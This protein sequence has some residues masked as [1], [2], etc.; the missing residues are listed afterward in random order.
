MAQRPRGGVLPV[1]ACDGG[2]RHDTPGGQGKKDISP[3]EWCGCPAACDRLQ[4]VQDI[5]TDERV[6]WMH[7]VVANKSPE[8]KGL[9]E[10]FSGAGGNANTSG[11]S[12]LQ[13][14]V[15]DWKQ[16]WLG[17]SGL[18]PDIQS[19]LSGSATCSAS[20]TRQVRPQ[21]PVVVAL[22]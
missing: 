5:D 6:P 11:E 16:P 18:P 20:A 4:V 13:E 8:E 19:R 9:P 7:R 21:D 15:N 10:G 17:Q 14:G 2:C 1:S 12:G 3:P 22:F